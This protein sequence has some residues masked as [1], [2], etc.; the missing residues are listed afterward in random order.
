MT[1]VAKAEQPRFYSEIMSEGDMVGPEV[2]GEIPQ[3][4]NPRKAARPAKKPARP[5]PKQSNQERPARV[6]P[7]D[8]IGFQKQLTLLRSY[9][10]VSGQ[11]GKPATN[12][13]V[14]SLLKLH[15]S[16]STLAMPFFLDI[17]L[18]EKAGSGYVPSAEVLSF[19]RAFSWNPETAA[20]KLSPLLRSTWF[21]E[22]LL[23]KLALGQIDEKEAI[24]D[25]AESAAA[26]PRYEGQLRV[27]LEYLSAAGL[28][29]REGGAIREGN[30]TFDVDAGPRTE[31]FARSETGSAGPARDQREG[32]KMPNI[33]TAF[34]QAAEGIVHF[35]VEVRVDMAEF[36]NWRPERISAFFSGIAQVLAAKA[37]VEG[38]SAR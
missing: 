29:R 32:A 17:G 30:A 1:C 23:P 38:G 24:T 31:S 19:H 13:E 11:S 8:R 9:A 12:A 25:L 36:A 37:E 28:I 5:E 7:T 20:Q 3:K 15:P 34:S 22:R 18:L 27:I 4:D 6:L 10:A 26:G 33:A 16:T 2:V 14:S 35:H 21:A